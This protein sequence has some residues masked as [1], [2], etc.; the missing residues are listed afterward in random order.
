MKIGFHFVNFDV[1]GGVAAL[2]ATLA[3]AARTA[4]QPGAVCSPWP[5]TSFRWTTSSPPSR[6][7]YTSLGYLAGQTERCSPAPIS[8]RAMLALLPI[9]TS[10]RSATAH[11]K[12]ARLCLSISLRHPFPR[13]ETA[14][15]ATAQ[16]RRQ[17]PRNSHPPTT[18][19]R[20]RVSVQSTIALR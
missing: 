14:S 7:C 5:A 8:R 10:S 6:R 4:E 20:E 17:T 3:S 11:A 2:P 13:R 16:L 15:A 18:N 12:V 9:R 1:P 19:G